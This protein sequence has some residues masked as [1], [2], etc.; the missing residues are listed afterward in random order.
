MEISSKGEGKVMFSHINVTLKKVL[1]KGLNVLKRDF[2]LNLVFGIS[3]SRIVA[4][5][6]SVIGML[7]GSI[8][9]MGYTTVATLNFF[10]NLDYYFYAA[11]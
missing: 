11:Y 10:K 3:L 9:F 8:F 4:Y 2:L 1:T 6:D 7:I 5:E